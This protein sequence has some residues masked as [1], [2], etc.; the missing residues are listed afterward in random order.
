MGSSRGGDTLGR[1]ASVSSGFA[2]TEKVC[3]TRFLLGWRALLPVGAESSAPSMSS[4]NCRV[5]V[6]VTSAFPPCTDTAARPAGW[7]TAVAI[8]PSPC[9]FV[10]SNSTVTSCR[11]SRLTQDVVQFSN[12]EKYPVV[13]TP[14]ST[15]SYDVLEKVK[16]CSHAPSGG[17]RTRHA[18]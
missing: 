1:S 7:G 15:L 10:S 8:T 5:P 16:I 9:S 4:M 17:M 13:S 18:K 3:T 14:L 2:K 6:T 12:D 11:T